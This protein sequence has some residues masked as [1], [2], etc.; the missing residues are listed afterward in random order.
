MIFRVLDQ[1]KHDEREWIYQELL[2]I[3]K[4]R[5][6]VYWKN[7]MFNFSVAEE[8]ENRRKLIRNHL[9]FSVKLARVN[10]NKYFFIAHMYD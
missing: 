4:D 10:K 9:D 1:E 6:F 7:Y 8:E 3:S 5:F 2:I